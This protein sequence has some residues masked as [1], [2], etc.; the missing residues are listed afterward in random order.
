MV[1]IDGQAQG[2]IIGVFEEARQN[3]RCALVPLE[4]HGAGTIAKE[5]AGGAI[6]PV[7][8]ARE[9]LRTHDQRTAHGVALVADAAS[10]LA[11]DGGL[12]HGGG[13]VDAVDAAAT[14]G[15]KVK[16]DGMLGAQLRLDERSLGRHDDVPGDGHAHDEVDISGRNPRVFEGGLCS[17]D[18]KIGGGL[19]NRDAAVVDAGA[20]DDPFVARVDDVC[21]VIV[22]HDELRLGLSMSDDLASHGVSPC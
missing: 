12:D 11:G 8:D 5:H 7:G 19:L 15:V 4:H 3:A 18:S 14:R 17:L 10:A 9:S 22:A 21:Q 16:C 6:G 13:D 20:L 2:V 1:R